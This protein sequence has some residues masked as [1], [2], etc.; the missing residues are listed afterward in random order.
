M[1]FKTVFEKQICKSLC[2]FAPG[3]SSQWETGKQGVVGARL[4]CTSD[5]AYR[6]EFRDFADR[7]QNIS[8]FKIQSLCPILGLPESIN[9]ST[10]D[11]WESLAG[12]HCCWDKEGQM[13]WRDSSPP[14]QSLL[15]K[16]EV[17]HPE[18]TLHHRQKTYWDLHQCYSL[19][20]QTYASWCGMSGFW[21]I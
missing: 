2:P 16:E 14:K 6:A 12:S 10:K 8:M 19:T 5:E 1:G 11:V 9:K 18:T 13:G 17:R 7:K 15:Y 3:Y 20:I 21:L 4:K